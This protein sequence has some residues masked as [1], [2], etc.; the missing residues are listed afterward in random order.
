MEA[1]MLEKIKSNLP[2]LPAFGLVLYGFYLTIAITGSVYSAIERLIIITAIWMMCALLWRALCAIAESIALKK[3]V[4][5]RTP[6]D[7]AYKVRGRQ[8]AITKGNTLPEE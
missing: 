5:P 6:V 1:R 4:S 8:A 7:N 2:A 3:E